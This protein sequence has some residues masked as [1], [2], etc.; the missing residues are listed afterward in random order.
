MKAI[1]LAEIQRA[2]ERIADSVL[3][4]PLLQFDVADAPCQLYLKLENLQ[5]IGSFKLRGAGNAIYLAD[6]KQLAK[7][8]WTASAGNMA[9]GVAWHARALDIACHV[10]VPDHAPQTKLDAIQRLGGKII[11]VPFASWWQTMVAGEF[12]GLDGLFIHPV[13]DPAVIAGNGTIGLEILRDLPA[14]D[15]IVIPYGGGGLSAGIASAIRAIKPDTR[16]YAAEVE[17]AAPL[18]ASLTAGQPVA[19]DY[20]PSFVDGIGGASV[21]PEMWDMVS[22]LLDGSLVVSLDEAR[23]AIRRLALRARVIAE[24]AGAASVAAALSGRAGAGKV[25]C[26]VS[27]GNI[28]LTTLAGILTQASP[29]T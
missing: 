12:A 19:I 20:Q 15:A 17:T 14:V 21:L 25:V 16:I 13:S 3:R 24:G 27:G 29:Y 6:R 18:A 22:S 1:P 8:V 9:Q 2:A 11:S 10:V 5:P 28:N 7:G 26:V 4:S 23:A